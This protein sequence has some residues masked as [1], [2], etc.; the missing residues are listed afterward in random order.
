M[1]ASSTPLSPN[2]TVLINGQELA[3]LMIRYEVGVRARTS[4][5]IKTVD[6]DYF[7]DLTAG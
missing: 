5:V 7:A 2:R 4:Y 1:G 6:E 3:R